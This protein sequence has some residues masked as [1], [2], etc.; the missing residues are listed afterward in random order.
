M[1]PCTN[2]EA[3]SKALLAATEAYVRQELQHNDGSHDYSHIER[4][5]R[6]AL[7]LGTLEG[8]DSNSMLV[9]ELSA[10]LHDVK[11]VHVRLVQLNGILSSHVSLLPSQQQPVCF[12]RHY[13][14]R[15]V[16]C[17]CGV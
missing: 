11:G 10:L 14:N 17:S 16:C 13:C 9:V 12:L 15:H 4:V 1:A 8:L 6:T 2:D 7:H 5:R 3:A